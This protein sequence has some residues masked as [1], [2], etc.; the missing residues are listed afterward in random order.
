MGDYN[1]VQLGTIY[2][3]DN[4]L[5]GGLPCRI[6]TQGVDDLALLFT[7]SVVKSGNGTPYVFILENTSGVDLQLKPFVISV[8]VFNDIKDLI[9]T[10]TDDADTLDL[11]ITGDVVGTLTMT[12]IPTFPKALPFPGMQEN[13]T[14]Q[15]ASINLTMVSI[16]R[17]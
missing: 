11:I 1:L 12:C 5:V 15:N 10:V 2:F 9:D 7:G 14:F 8:D 17:T 13:G 6:D 3:T 4:G 16:I